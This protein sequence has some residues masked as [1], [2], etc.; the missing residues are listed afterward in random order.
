MKNFSRFTSSIYQ[1]AVADYRC[2]VDGCRRIWNGG[3]VDIDTC[4][5]LCCLAVPCIYGFCFAPRTSIVLFIIIWRLYS[6]WPSK[7]S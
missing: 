5:I 1:A 7:D 3:Y 4:V 6:R 2:V